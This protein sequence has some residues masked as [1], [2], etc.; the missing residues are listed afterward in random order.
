VKGGAVVVT[1]AFGVLRRAAARPAV[2][3]GVC[4]DLLDI[5]AS[6]QTEITSLEQ[7]TVAWPQELT[8]QRPARRN[9]PW[10]G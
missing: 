10:R 9:G 6:P 2:P 5:A 8:C 4:L 3:Q 1:G 7:T